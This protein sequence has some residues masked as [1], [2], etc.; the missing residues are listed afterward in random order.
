MTVVRV[1]AVYKLTFAITL[2]LQLSHFSYSL[3]SIL[4][5]VLWRNKNAA[6]LTSVVPTIVSQFGM[7]TCFLFLMCV[8]S[9]RFLILVFHYKVTAVQ[10][11]LTSTICCSFIFLLLVGYLFIFH[12]LSLSQ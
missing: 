1:A 9:P 4:E 10:E 2:N 12:V 3:S 8:I 11:N 6:A 7:Y 5:K